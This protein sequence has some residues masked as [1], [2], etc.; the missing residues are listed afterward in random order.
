MCTYDVVSIT[1]C[2][3]HSGSTC[4]Q[5]KPDYA[6]LDTALTDDGMGCAWS[7]L[8]LIVVYPNV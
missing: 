6:A 7:C 2:T 1:L 5:D 4:S 8:I 3:G